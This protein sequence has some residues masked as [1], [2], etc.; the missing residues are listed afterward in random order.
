MF[1][2]TEGCLPMRRW[3]EPNAF[4]EKSVAKIVFGLNALNSL[5]PLQGGAPWEE[6]GTPR[7][8][9]CSSGTPPARATKSMAGSSVWDREIILT[10]LAEHYGKDL[11]HDITKVSC[12]PNQP[13]LNGWDKAKAT[14]P[15][16]YVRQLC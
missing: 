10:V 1:G 3:D 14:K 15:P 8:R 16:L 5:V 6:T 4:F 13:A 9:C 7:T 2:F 12:I 11:Q